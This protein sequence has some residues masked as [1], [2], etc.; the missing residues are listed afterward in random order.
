[1]REWTDGVLGTVY[2]RTST[3][4][5][6]SPYVVGDTL[7]RT[8]LYREIRRAQDAQAALAAKNEKFKQIARI[9]RK[10]GAK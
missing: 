5:T 2:D 7:I 4:N 1:M 8:E 3:A 9:N 10:K 6:L